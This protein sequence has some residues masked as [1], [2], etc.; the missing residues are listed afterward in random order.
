MS[1]IQYFQ[2][3]INQSYRCNNDKWLEVAQSAERTNLIMHIQKWM[4]ATQKPFEHAD[5][6]LNNIG[7]R[8]E[9][10]DCYLNLAISALE[11][12]RL[13]LHCQILPLPHSKGKF[14]SVNK[15]MEDLNLFQF[16]N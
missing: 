11:Y 10:C 1:K 16:L 5:G 12:T 9:N 14:M 15:I 3:M 7:I 13:N 8:T 4:L 2:N 6:I